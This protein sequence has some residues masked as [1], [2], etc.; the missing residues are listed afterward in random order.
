MNS[1]EIKANTFKLIIIQVNPHKKKKIIIKGIINNLKK[2][3][4]I[5]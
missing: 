2:Q 3:Q 4:E 5:I 1:N